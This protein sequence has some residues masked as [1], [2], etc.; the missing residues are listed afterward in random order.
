MNKI[1]LFAG[2]DV[3]SETI[4][5]TIKDEKGNFIRVMKVETSPKGVAKLF[6]RMKRKNIKAVFEA[7]RNWLYIVELLKPYCNEIV[8]AHPLRVRA[9]A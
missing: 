1:Y 7:S 8:M 5:G 4:T 9:I 3:H 2:L 6:E